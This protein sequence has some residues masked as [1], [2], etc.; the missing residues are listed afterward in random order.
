MWKIENT[1]GYGDCLVGNGYPYSDD[2]NVSE[3][4]TYADCSA[5]APAV[6]AG[7]PRDRRMAVHQKRYLALLLH[8]EEWL[9]T[10]AGAPVV[11]GA[12][13]LRSSARPTSTATAHVA[14]RSCRRHGWAP[15]RT[16]P[17]LCESN[18][19]TRFFLRAG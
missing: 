19:A 5:H 15:P 10:M 16:S 6:A 11:L 17:V 12:I 3:S 4:E 8:A 1:R 9:N 2:E 18:H 13:A 7:S 14:V